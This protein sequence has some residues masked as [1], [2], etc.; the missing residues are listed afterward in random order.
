MVVEGWTARASG[1]QSSRRRCWIVLVPMICA[2]LV[3]VLA[4]GRAGP[5]R[6]PAAPYDHTGF[7][8]VSVATEDVVAGQARSV[9]EGLEERGHWWVQ[10]RSNDLAAQIACQSSERGVQVDMVVA[11]TGAVLYYDT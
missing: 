7:S 4:V 5:A 3:L 9:A 8:E 11:L 10:P 6:G 2:V 1:L